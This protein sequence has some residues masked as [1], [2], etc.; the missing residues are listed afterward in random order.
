MSRPTSSHVEPCVDGP[1]AGARFDLAYQR[2]AEEDARRSAWLSERCHIAPRAPRPTCA[3]PECKR[4]A[5]VKELCPAHNSQRLRGKPLTPISPR[6]A[7]P[8]E[9]DRAR[10]E[11][12]RSG[13][14]AARRV[15]G[16]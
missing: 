13:S 8:A 7:S 3:G 15:V 2:L 10:A 11:L 5:E 12:A 6:A 16:V 9:V 14:E 1:S 4:P